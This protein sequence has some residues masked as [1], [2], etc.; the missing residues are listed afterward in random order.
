MEMQQIIEMLKEMAANRQTDKEEMKTAQDE[1]LARMEANRQ[2][3]KYGLQNKML[4]LISPGC[5]ILHRVVPH[6]YCIVRNACV[7]HSMSSP[8][9]QRLLLSAV[10]NY[11]GSKIF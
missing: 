6:C 9:W 3:D 1:M 7:L 11:L 8:L 5:L 10:H 2:T 4:G